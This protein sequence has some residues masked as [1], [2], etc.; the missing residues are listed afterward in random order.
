M[1][2]ESLE[3]AVLPQSITAI[4]SYTFLECVFLKNVTISNNITEIGQDAFNGCASLENFNVPASVTSIGEY[5]FWGCNLN[6]VVISNDFAVLGERAFVE[7]NIS[8]LRFFSVVKKEKYQA[9]I[10]ANTV[11]CLC[12][13]EEHAFSSE[14]DITCNERL[15]R[16][17]CL[18]KI[19]AALP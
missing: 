12:E 11:I 1:L 3:T 8:T 9:E 18:K 10:S 5:A 6:E 2:C 15:P 13:N 16:P 14:F 17:F 19:F 7:A 4:P